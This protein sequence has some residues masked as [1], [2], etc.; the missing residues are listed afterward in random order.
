MKLEGS[1]VALVTPYSKGE[2]DLQKVRELVDFHVKNGT[3]GLCPAATT[4]EGPSLSPEEKAAVIKAVVETA[5]GKALVFPG[6]G[7]YNTQESIA[8]TKMAKE[9]GADGALV[10]TPYYNKPTQEG[11]FRHFEAISKG[12]TGFPLILYNVPSRTGVSLNVE[13]TARLSKIK[14]IV[15]LKDASGNVEQVTQLRALSDIQILSGEDSLTFPILCLGGRGVISVAANII[16]KA[17]AEMC[18]AVLKGDLEK[19]RQIHDRYF[20]VFKGL[21]IETNPIPVKTALKKMGMYNGEMRLPMCEMTAA[22]G[23][24]LEKVLKG[25]KVI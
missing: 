21:F 16:P 10:V 25:C 20:E 12:A 6:T 8:Q 5:R 1:F 7:T 2:V 3:S 15:A 9:L 18:A 23:E 11:L 22:N 4:G 13:T 19:G 24:K 17:V 14:T